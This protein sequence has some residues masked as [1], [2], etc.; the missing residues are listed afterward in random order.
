VIR[1]LQAPQTEALGGFIYQ[2]AG[3]SDGVGTA[4]RLLVFPSVDTN[5]TAVYQVSGVVPYVTVQTAREQTRRGTVQSITLSFSGPLDRASAQNRLDY[6]LV[7][8][9]RDKIFGTRDDKYYRYR[10]VAYSAGA[11]TVKLVPS[12]KLTTRQ[13]LEVIAVASGSRGLVRDAYGRPIDGNKDGQ[14]G[15]DFVGIFNPGQSVLNFAI[16]AQALARRVK[17]T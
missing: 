4:A 16:K 10:S 6:W 15:G 9:G 14:P 5:L 7:L 13:S 2:F 17:R 12:I 3:W 1:G 11:N 8:P